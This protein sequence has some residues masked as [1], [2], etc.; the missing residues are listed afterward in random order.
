MSKSPPLVGKK[1][2]PTLPMFSK[3]ESK[4]GNTEKERL[5]PRVDPLWNNLLHSLRSYIKKNITTFLKALYKKYCDIFKGLR[6]N[7]IYELKL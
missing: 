6:R 3:I 1:I 5:C 4:A 2:L 7:H